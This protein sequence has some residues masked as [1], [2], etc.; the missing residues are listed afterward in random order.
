M[1][2]ALPTTG[3][4]ISLM[5]ALG[6][7]FFAAVVFV[8]VYPL[9]GWTQSA[10]SPFEFIRRGLPRWWTWFDVLSNLLAYVLLGLLLALGW[11]TRL[12][13]V[14]TALTVGVLCSA[15]SFSLEGVQSFL[16]ARVPSLLDWLSNSAGALLGGVLGGLLNHSTRDLGRRTLPGGQRWFEQ[17]APSGWVLLLLWLSTQLVPQRLLFAT[18]DLRTSLQSLLVSLYGGEAPDLNLRIERLWDGPTPAAIGVAIE[19]AVVVCAVCVIGLLSFTLVRA[20]RQ[21]VALLAG[22]AA[23]AFGLHSIATQLVYGADEPFA[24]LTPGAQGGLVVGAALLYALETLSPRARALGGVVLGAA[25]MLLVNL[26][27]E[28]SYFDH[29]LAGM[30]SGQLVN[31]QGLLR[32]VSMLWPLAAIG[33]FAQGLR[34]RKPRWL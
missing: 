26:A 15:L 12:S 8:T 22:I 6:L 31:L 4:T 11:L 25:G 28:D 30:R 7:L 1:I 19:A 21:R 17:G 18:G 13:V 5:R 14:R 29:A 9:S 2:D 3:R 32:A 24:W 23:I 16:P 33:W 34:K 27:P 10:A 20:A